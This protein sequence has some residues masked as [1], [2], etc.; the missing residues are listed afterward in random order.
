MGGFESF[1]TAP[2]ATPA[3]DPNRS[4]TGVIALTDNIVIILSATDKAL[5]RN[6][7]YW[8]HVRAA[9][10][11]SRRNFTDQLQAFCDYVDPQGDKSS[12]PKA[13]FMRL[14]TALYAPL[15]LTSKL[16]HKLREATSL[17]NLRDAMP[18][19]V[20]FAL[21]VL[22]DDLSAYLK[23]AIQKGELRTVIKARIRDEAKKMAVFCGVR[24]AA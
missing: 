23:E 9:G 14:T 12:D 5:A 4:N 15:G 18:P 1:G 10:K 6:D 19:R 17:G 11:V 21:S 24:K 22:E 8:E 3:A 16:I 13:A 2:V 7:Q 20:L